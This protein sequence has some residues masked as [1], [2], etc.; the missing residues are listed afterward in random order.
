MAGPEYAHLAGRPLTY[1]ELAQLPLICLGQDSSTFAF[2]ARL[3]AENGAVLEPDVQTATTDQLV[4]LVR[5]GLGLAFVPE[6]F[7]GD[8]LAKGEVVRLT[9]EA[10]PAP[11]LYQPG[12]RQKPPAQRRCHGTGADAAGGVPRLNFTATA[13]S[14][15]RPGRP[16]SG[17]AGGG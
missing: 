7:A 14:S 10:P 12:E 1:G 2:Y 11:A 6:D 8:A 15:G 3:F 4:P 17:P 16:A 13:A 9:L 5:Y